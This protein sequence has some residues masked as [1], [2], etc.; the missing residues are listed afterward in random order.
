MYWV[1]II[2]NE[3]GQYIKIKLWLYLPTLWLKSLSLYNGLM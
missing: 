1:M 3:F 2:H